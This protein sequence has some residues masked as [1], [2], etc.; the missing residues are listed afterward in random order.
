VRRRVLRV[1]RGMCIALFRQAR[2]A[3]A[4][5]VGRQRSGAGILGKK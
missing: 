2:L 5:P 1:D 4:P 3:A